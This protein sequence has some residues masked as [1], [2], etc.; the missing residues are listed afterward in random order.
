MSFAMSVPIASAPPCGFSR[1]VARSARYVEQFCTGLNIDG[2]EQRIDG[3]PCHLAY[4]RIVMYCLFA[5]AGSLEL[6]E[7]LALLLAYWSL[8]PK[9]AEKL[10]FAIF[11]GLFKTIAKVHG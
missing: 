4:E 2:G 11:Q 1:D 7:C 10:I 6:F 9:R 5:P 3:L 8:P